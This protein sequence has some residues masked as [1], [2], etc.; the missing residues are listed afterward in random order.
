MVSSSALR[1]GAAPWPGFVGTSA[2]PRRR[3]RL[4]QIPV[5]VRDAGIV[6]DIDRARPVLVRGA[7]VARALH[8]GDALEAGE[9]RRFLGIAVVLERAEARIGAGRRCEEPGPEV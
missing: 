8:G 4:I 7:V 2:I 3:A 6:A 1:A 5:D 9:P